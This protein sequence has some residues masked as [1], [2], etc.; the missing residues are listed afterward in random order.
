MKKSTSTIA[1]LFATLLLACHGDN[2]FGPEKELQEPSGTVDQHALQGQVHFDVDVAAM[3]KDFATWYNY[4]HTN[5]RLSRP[6]VG[7]NEAAD[8]VSK[9]DFLQLLE[10]GGS[11]PFKVAMRQQL[12]VYQLFRVKELDNDIQ[13][14]VQQMATTE[15]ALGNMEGKPLPAYDFR[16][17]KGIRYNR[18][19]TAGKTLLLKCWFINCFACVQEFPELNKLVA[20]YQGND[21]VLFISL[22]S[23]SEHALSSFLKKK[24]FSYA[25]I[26]EQDSYMSEQLGITAYP[27]HILVDKSGKIVKATHSLDDMLPFLN[28]QMGRN[29]NRGE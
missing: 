10:R 27:T 26:P 1:L 6:F 24:P 5:I 14:T 18:F 17:I 8:V 2:K 15:Q 23:D 25:V 9:A 19:T 13:L 20:S 7:M 3:T 11:L 28:R 4:T 21:D 16:D 29:G 22:A 12:P